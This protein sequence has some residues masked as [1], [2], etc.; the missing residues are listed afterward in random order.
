MKRSRS[1]SAYGKKR[2]RKKARVETT[3]AIVRQEINRRVD[4]KYTDFGTLAFNIGTGGVMSSVFFNMS[5]GDQGRNQFE[6][7]WIRPTGWLFRYYMHT[8][9]IRNC[10]RILLFQWLDATVPVASGVLQDISAGWGVI[11]PTLVTNRN[12]IRVLYDRTHQIAPQAGNA[13]TLGG[14]GISPVVKVW[15]PGKKLQKV[16]F[17]SGANTVQRGDLYVLAISD[18]V[19][20]P[21]PQ[22][23]FW[24]RV[25]YSDTI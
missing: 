10:V 15:I 4:L 3:R 22:L 2:Y 8:S 5:R 25:T 6:G 11:S 23:T 18:D 17:Q 20:L 9:E 7:N 24:S 21:Q 14:E 1:S 19:I 12:Y 16:R 13:G